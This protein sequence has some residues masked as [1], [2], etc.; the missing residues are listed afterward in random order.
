MASVHPATVEP[1]YGCTN[2][3]ATNYNP[4]ATIDDGSCQLQATQ[5]RTQTSGEPVTFSPK[6]KPTTDNAVVEKRRR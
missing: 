1:V 6:K 3:N 5:T 2:P 4:N